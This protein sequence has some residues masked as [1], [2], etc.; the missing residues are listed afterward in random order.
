MA[1]DEVDIKSIHPKDYLK[2]GFFDSDGNLREGING[3]CSLAMAYQCRDESLQPD[4][5]KHVLDQL[6]AL[7][8]AYFKRGG[9]TA[10]DPL[11][12]PTLS[13]IDKISRGR[14]VSGSKALE[15]LFGAAKPLLKNWQNFSGLVVHLERIMGQLALVTK[16]RF[17]PQLPHSK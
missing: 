14:E 11:D 17:E 2:D 9:N 3:T 1:T 12:A 8:E 7:G 13:A 16:T 4:A 15:S 10:T 5:V 6:T